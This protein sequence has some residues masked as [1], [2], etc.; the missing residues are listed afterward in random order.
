[1]E[2]FKIPTEILDD[3]EL[4]FL[5]KLL[6]ILIN[7]DNLKYKKFSNKQ[8]ASLFGVGEQIITNAISSLKKHNLIELKMFDGRNREL[9]S[10]YHK[11][12]YTKKV[13]PIRVYKSYKTYLMS[14]G[15]FIKIGKSSNPVAREETLQ[16]LQPSIKLILVIQLNIERS[17]HDEFNEKRIRGE[18]FDLSE[19]D[20]ENIKNKYKEYICQ[21]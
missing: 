20:V 10:I 12:L 2:D 1:M 5:E 6:F 9:S 13:K 15:V 14:D 7:N 19:E 18:W 21:S 11:N 17:L 3:R 16:A 8:F 4:T